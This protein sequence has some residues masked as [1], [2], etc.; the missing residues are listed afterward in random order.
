M[1]LIGGNLIKSFQTLIRTV[2]MLDQ[3]CIRGVRANEVQCRRNF[4]NSAGLATILNPALGYDRVAE[5][6]KEGL[7]RN[8]SL[9]EMV[10][11]KKLMTEDELQ[12]LLDGAFGPNS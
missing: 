9:K 5:L 10:S 2:A 7:D 1:P 4:E 12:R 3:K 8:I 6:V 11:E